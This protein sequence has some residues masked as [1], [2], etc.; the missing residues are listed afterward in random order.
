MSVAA[1][2]QPGTISIF[3]KIT[4]TEAVGDKG[5][6]QSLIVCPSLDPYEYPKKYCV[7][8]KRKFGKKDDEVEVQAEVICRPWKDGKGNW[9]YPHQL[10]A[11]E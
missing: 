4:S 3:G 9:H 10:W 1:D 11:V 5:T 8:S 6:F 2:I 7:F